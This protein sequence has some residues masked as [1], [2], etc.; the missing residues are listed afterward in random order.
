MISNRYRTPARTKDVAVTQGIC[1]L[2][3]HST[4][5]W[6]LADNASAFASVDCVVLEHPYCAVHLWPEILLGLT[7]TWVE[8]LGFL[9]P[10]GT[11]IF[12]KKGQGR[13]GA[14]HKQATDSTGKQPSLSNWLFICMWWFLCVQLQTPLIRL[15]NQELPCQ[16]TGSSKRTSWPNHWSMN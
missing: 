9:L 7:K 14:Y 8:K 12:R 10:E 13:N 1:S 6:I 3:P 5:D 4:V 16:S 11:H 15:L 2:F